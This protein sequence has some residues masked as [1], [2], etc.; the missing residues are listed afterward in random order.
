MKRTK[1]QINNLL[2][3]IAQFTILL[4]DSNYGI[5]YEPKYLNFSSFERIID[6][7]LEYW[8]DKKGGQGF[9]AEWQNIRNKFNSIKEYLESIGDSPEPRDDILN[10]L[11]SNLS[12]DRVDNNGKYTY[13]ISVNSPI[14]SDASWRSIDRFI[15]FY[16]DRVDDGRELSDAIRRY[17]ELCRNPI[18][19][20][21]SLYQNYNYSYYPALF[22]LKDELSPKNVSIKN[23]EQKT[24]RPARD[25]LEQLLQEAGESQQEITRFI[26]EKRKEVQN[27]VDKNIAEMDDYKSK[28]ND[29]EAKKHKELD[30]LED[31]YRKK[32][33]LEAPEEL[34]NE[35]SEKYRKK[36]KYW[37]VGL[38]VVAIIL[39]FVIAW[40]VHSLHEFPKG[41]TEK[42]PF[43]SQQVL[44]IG[45]ISF[46]VYIIRVMVKIVM[47][48]HHIAMEYEQKA[49]LTRFYQ[50]LTYEGIEVDD[51]EKLIIMSALFSKVDTGLVK[52][53][54]S[55]DLDSVLG[56]IARNSG[57]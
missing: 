33:Q 21:S 52:T 27:Q 39:L 19:V 15:D 29:W 34:L 45:A 23:F 53:N 51:N 42:V 41:I 38:C 12:H 22:I 7:N 36:A 57:K 35:R 25:K 8:H 49:A 31:T 16:L 47:S 20:G 28:V 44:F 43:L 6:E 13:R 37:T 5:N 26:E 1:A 3:D 50:A 17:V 11:L 32:L 55:V 48:N 14:I 46:F 30:T 10:Y 54:E 9:H 40:F 2:D 4:S 24:L 18:Q 56:L